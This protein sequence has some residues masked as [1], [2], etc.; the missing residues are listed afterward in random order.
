MAIVLDVTHPAQGA[1]TIAAATAAAFYALADLGVGEAI[2][3]TI[4]PVAAST[5]YV[6]GNY[7]C[8][9]ADASQTGG[10][11]L[12]DNTLRIFTAGADQQGLNQ[13]MTWGAGQTLRFRFQ[14]P[15]GT[16]QVVISQATTGN[17]TFSL[18]QTGPFFAPAQ[19]LG[20][21]SVPGLTLYRFNGA[22]GDVD[23]TVT[24][25]A[26]STSAPQP[27]MTSAANASSFASISA[28]APQPT[29]TSAATSAGVG[30]SISTTAPQPSMTSATATAGFAAVS[31]SAPQPTM[32]SAAATLS[33]SLW[34]QIGASGAAQRIH[35]SPPATGSLTTAFAARVPSATVAQN[36]RLVFN[37]RR[38]HVH[39]AGT[40][41]AG[42]GPSGSTGVQAD[43]TAQVV[44]VAGDTE[45]SMTTQPANS[46]ML[47][48]VMRNNYTADSSPPTGNKG[49]T[50]AIQGTQH[51]YAGWS[52]AATAVYAALPGWAG[53]A[54][55]VVSAT[56]PADGGSGAEASVLAVEVPTGSATSYVHQVA[57]AEVAAPGGGTVAGPSVTTTAPAMIV[58][59]HLGAD[60]VLTPIGSS[61]PGTAQAP[62]E[63][64]TNADCRVSI[65]GNGYVQGQIY[66]WFAP[67]P[68]TWAPTW[69]TT[70]PAQLYTVAIQEVAGTTATISTS[71]PQPGMTSAAT[72]TASAAIT[73]SA[74]QPS[75]TSATAAAGFAAVATAAP[76]PAVTSAA[77]AVGAGF[78]AIAASAPQPSMTSS[79][80]VA[81]FAAIATS[82]PQPTMT[83]VAEQPGV[84]TVTTSAPQPD[85]AAVAITETTAAIST[86]APQPT[87]TSAAGGDSAFWSV[88]IRRCPAAAALLP[89]ERAMIEQRLD[90]QVPAGA[91]DVARVYLAR[92][93]AELGA[94]ASR[95][96]IGLVQS[97]TLGPS[98]TTYATG[99]TAAAGTWGLTRWGALYLA[100]VAGPGPELV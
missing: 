81:G 65:H 22:I 57:F 37:G 55:H 68:G 64:A 47:A 43:G 95:G 32:T 56:Y 26:I 34:G 38:W 8:L 30:A 53:G 77:I 78:A 16:R 3:F 73:T 46:V 27:T 18:S 58:A 11:W 17:G 20:V 23:D 80:A 24:G 10:I 12:V 21:G 90:A 85:M 29:V 44:P 82:A 51:V 19:D 63:P 4:T 45:L 61:H 25:A 59:A 98:S 62:F 87:V 9:F 6:G 97:Q 86:S 84:A 100:C 1:E 67:G 75:M 33:S 42:S 41:S 14:N 79:T 31:T 5:S 91:P 54:G 94:M 89:V 36:D 66:Y 88:V 39:T 49:E 99:G 83:S 76:Q 93:L 92:H 71:A 48:W 50:Y 13:A 2:E 52:T 69:N 70:A 72:T 7:W 40:L 35:L 28:S 74:P 60:A 15:S 96:T